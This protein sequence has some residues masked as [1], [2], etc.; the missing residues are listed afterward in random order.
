MVTAEKEVV[1]K[2]DSRRLRD[3]IGSI[4]Q[5][6]PTPGHPVESYLRDLEGQLARTA[7]V[8]SRSV[9]AGTVTMNSKVRLRDL[10]SGTSQVVT[11]VYEADADPF[12]EKLSVLSGLGASLLGARVGDVVEWQTRRGARRLRV[13][14]I[15]FQRRLNLCAESSEP[16]A[17]VCDPCSNPDPRT[18]RRLD[19]CSKRSSKIRSDDSSTR[20]STHM[21]KSLNV[22][23]IVPR[24]VL[25]QHRSLGPCSSFSSVTGWAS[26][27][28]VIVTGTSFDI[29]FAGPS[30][31]RSYNFR[32]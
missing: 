18:G 3:M 25:L 17:H 11:L 32:Q 14:R 15:L 26:A 5:S 2:A 30:R 10:D 20:P 19:Y 6:L 24:S 28:S 31:P 12:G 1:T 27:A 22:T 23:C 29:L 21:C 7:I 13:E 4:R 16:T 9:D 8:Q